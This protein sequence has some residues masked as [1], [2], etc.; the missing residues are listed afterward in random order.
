MSAFAAE[1][2]SVQPVPSEHRQVR[3]APLPGSTEILLV[4]HGES[5]P[6]RPGE[7]FPLVDGHG[8]PPLAPDGLNQALAVGERLA[9]ETI[10]AIYV[11][12]LQRTHQTAQPLADRLG[13][14]P[15]VE[16]DLREIFLGEWEGGLLRQKGAEEDPI[17]L[18]MHAEQDWGVIP[19]AESMAVLQGRCVAAIARI[20]AAHPDERVAVFVHGG[21]I[22]ALCGYATGSR[23][24]AFNGADNGSIHHLVVLDQEW[25]L[26]C[27]ND[28]AHLGPFTSAAQALT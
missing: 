1:P 6:F 19:G 26:R 25:K 28:T 23:P 22:G 24:F 8:D 12:S 5:A 20:H 21:V 17:Y 16:R 18:R 2:H 13:L 9:R 3:Y 27:F 14:Q 10:H 11:T 7:P 15:I 4:R